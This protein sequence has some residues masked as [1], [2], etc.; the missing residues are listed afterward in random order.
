MKKTILELDL[1]N[2]SEKASILEAHFDSRSVAQLNEQ[3]QGFINHGLW[4]LKLKREEV[5]IKTTGDGAILAF[6]QPDHAHSFARH[7]HAVTQEHNADK[8][9]PSAMRVFRMGAA[10]GDITIQPQPNGS[11]D[12]AGTTIARA[13]RLETAAQPG[14]LL[15]DPDTYDLLPKSI[16]ISYRD[17]ETVRGKGAEKFQARGCTMNPNAPK[18]KRGSTVASTKRI[19]KGLTADLQQRCVRALMQCW[20][21][22]D[23]ITLEPLF[24]VE[25]LVRYANVLPLEARTQ[26]QLVSLLIHQLVS[27]PAMNGEP[28]TQLLE[29]LRDK[30]DR[31]E[32]QWEELDSLLEQVRSHLD[33]H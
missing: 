12:I 10:T 11:L 20:E 27:Y 14:D 15:I 16:Q 32:K 30:R 4:A 2:Y 33:Y 29:V 25:P 19:R 24:G 21:F 17:E 26:E 23:R 9:I 28:L 22:R 5:V 1:V 6:D 7:V 3:I 8:T 13:V 31:E 18:Q